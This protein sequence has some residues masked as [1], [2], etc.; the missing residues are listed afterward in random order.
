M[1]YMAIPKE[2]DKQISEALNNLARHKMIHRIYCDILV[3][4]QVCEIE[5][6]D[7]T[8][9]IRMLKEK[10]NSIEVS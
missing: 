9:Y 2:E 6:W 1:I 7:K 10:I 4:I 8:E 3:D 5:G